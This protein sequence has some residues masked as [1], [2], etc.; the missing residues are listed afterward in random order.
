[1]FARQHGHPDL[2]AARAACELTKQLLAA[3]RKNTFQL[4]KKSGLHK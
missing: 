1:V 2:V 4:R 3:S